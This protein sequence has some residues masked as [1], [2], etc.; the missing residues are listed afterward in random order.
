MRIIR[1]LT[2]QRF[3]KLVVEKYNRK[4]RTCHLWDCVCD[5]GNRKTIAHGSLVYGRTISC[6]CVLKQV[7]KERNTTHGLSDTVEYKTWKSIK[8]RC[9]DRNTPSFKDYGGRGITICDQW[10]R[11][12]EEFISH[13]GNCPDGCNSIDR[14]DNNRGYEPGNCRWSTPKEQSR[15]TRRNVFITANGTTRCIAEWSEITG[16]P[17]SCIYARLVRGWDHGRCVTP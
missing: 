12:F 14:I 11:S 10:E 9:L 17:Y 7:L 2:G 5:C 8:K 6:G 1:D 15:N 4:T 16:I 13:V 3:N